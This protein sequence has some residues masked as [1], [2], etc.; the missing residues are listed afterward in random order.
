MS[1]LFKRESDDWTTPVMEL[2]K[3]ELVLKWEIDK[4]LESDLQTHWATKPFMAII[5]ACN[6]EGSRN[7]LR[8]WEKKFIP[9]FQKETTIRFLL[10]GNYEIYGLVIWD[11]N[12]GKPHPNT[13]DLPWGSDSGEGIK[14]EPPT[15]CSYFRDMLKVKVSQ[16]SFCQSKKEHRSF[17]KKILKSL[18]FQ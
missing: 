11:R 13:I 16:E 7:Y 9:L 18:D 5:V 6:S 4:Y 1:R 15:E 14:V 8:I 10:P 12:G 2:E 17:W 3:P